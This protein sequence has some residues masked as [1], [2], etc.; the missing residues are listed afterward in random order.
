MALWSLGGGFGIE[1]G[2]VVSIYFWYSDILEITYNG[3]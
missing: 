3:K 2:I 1:S